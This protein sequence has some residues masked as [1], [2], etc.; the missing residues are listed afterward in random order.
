MIA[1]SVAAIVT[2]AANAALSANAQVVRVLRLI[3]ATDRYIAGAFI[4]RFAVRAVL[5][6]L[7]G[8]I[9][10]VIALALMPA[11]AGASGL[12]TG[13]SFTGAGWLV[14]FS[15]PLLSGVVALLATAAAARKALRDLA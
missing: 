12:L 10:G 6:A 15:I 4:R 2:L 11:G 9:L 1:A 14:P 8:T 13:L 3:G 7:A 5:G